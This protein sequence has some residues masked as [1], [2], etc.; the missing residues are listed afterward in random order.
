MLQA[1]EGEGYIGAVDSTESAF[2]ASDG[3]IADC[4]S[5]PSRR[6]SR[7]ALVISTAYGAPIPARISRMILKGM[8]YFVFIR[9][10][11]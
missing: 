6:R 7:S 8:L 11:A 10:N 9:D 5:V 3:I 2:E 4:G 1:A